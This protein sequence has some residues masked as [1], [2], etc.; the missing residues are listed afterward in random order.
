MS[1]EQIP[2]VDVE[3]RRVEFL[4]ELEHDLGA[5]WETGFAPG[6]FG[7]HELL[8]RTATTLRT[9][10]ENVLEHGACVRVPQWFELAERAAEALR[11][12]YQRIGDEHLAE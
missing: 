11:E 7:C 8:D 2:A 3:G 10:E 1:T 4:E 9:L 6:S 12:L 5:G